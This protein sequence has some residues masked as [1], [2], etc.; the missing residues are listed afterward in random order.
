[1]TLSKKHAKVALLTVASIPL[2]VA[3]KKYTAKRFDE[4]GN[5]LPSK[6][7]EFKDKNKEKISSLKSST[8]HK[9]KKSLDVISHAISDLKEINM[10]AKKENVK[11]NKVSEHK[12]GQT[13][14]AKETVKKAGN[15]VEK[16]ARKVVK[17]ATKKVSKVASK[18]A[19]KVV[20]ES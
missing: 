18:V 3:A 19:K 14:N 9:V 11:S 1:M 16:V 5:P 10:N 2:V 13:V 20:K 6:L 12:K 17:K 15:S 4:K 8:K 7:E